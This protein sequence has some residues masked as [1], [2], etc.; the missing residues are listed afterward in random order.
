MVNILEN[1][2]LKLYSTMRLGGTAR[3][4]CEINSEDDLLEAASWARLHHVAMRAIGVGSNVVWSDEGYSGLLL[5]MKIADFELLEEDLV[6]MGAGLNWDEAVKRTVDSGLSGIELLSL[7]PG[8][9]G[10]TPVQNVGAY[11]REIKDV[12]VSVRAYD[13]HEKS[14]VTIASGDCQF[15]YR[16]SRFKAVD[17]GRFIIC[18]IVL[19]LTN[20]PLEPPFYESLQNYIN[21]HSIT[22]YSPATIRS[23]VIA[24][25]SSKLPDPKQV[26][27]NGSFFENPIVQKPQYDE[28]LEKFSDLKGWPNQDGT[29]KLAA[30][31]LVEQAGFKNY[32]DAATGMGTW[33]EQSLV[34]VNEHATSTQD[35]LDFKQKI[36][37]AVDEKFGITL[38]QEPEILP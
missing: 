36:V 38:I 12:L 19:Q 16:T 4:A 13:L 17:N 31:W 1:V 34:V 27:N 21:E 6:R 29:V 14:F 9:V 32:H 15:G 33:G 24:L 22:E 7:I 2:S 23:A 8:T 28:L 18:S 11:G 35:L 10:A 25:R 20:S 3:Y 30:G 5:I 37:N 26:A